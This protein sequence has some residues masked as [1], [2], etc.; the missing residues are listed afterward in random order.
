MHP[1]SFVI[2]GIT[3]FILTMSKKIVLFYGSGIIIG[4]AIGFAVHNLAIGTGVGV[5]LG[6]A[7]VRSY[8]R[9]AGR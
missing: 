2:S 4:V 5:A 1:A 9:K 8:K 7:F 6:F 3:I